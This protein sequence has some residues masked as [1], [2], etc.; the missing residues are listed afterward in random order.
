MRRLQKPDGLP[1]LLKE[2]VIFNTRLKT[3]LLFYDKANIY[4][5]NPFQL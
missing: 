4:Y 1:V 5:Y 3:H 2:K